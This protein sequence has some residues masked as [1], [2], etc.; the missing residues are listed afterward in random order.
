MPKR[1]SRSI[2]LFSHNILRIHRTFILCFSW[3]QM[4]KI[5]RDFSWRTNSLLRGL[6]RLHA[7]RIPFERFLTFSQLQ[8]PK[9][10]S[11]WCQRN[12]RNRYATFSWFRTFSTA[13]MNRTHPLILYLIS[14]RNLF[15]TTRYQRQRIYWRSH[16]F[17][18]VIQRRV[19][20]SFIL[21]FFLTIDVL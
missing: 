5:N 8:N 6:F 14:F 13:K 11:K 9:I 2:S 20:H 19:R 15:F 17:M 7:W 21:L 1:N 12:I 18:S 4:T 10:V 3:S 16:S